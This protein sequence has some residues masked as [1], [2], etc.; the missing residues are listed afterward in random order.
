MDSRRSSPPGRL[1]FNLMHFGRLLRKAGM[2][3]G[4]AHLLDAIQTVEAV[5]L[6]NREDFYGALHAAFVKRRDEEPLFREAFDLFWRDPW[7][8]PNIVSLLLA[9]SSDQNLPSSHQTSRR[10]QEAWYARPDPPRPRPESD[11]GRIFEASMTWSDRATLRTKDFEQMSAEELTAAQRLLTRRPPWFGAPVSTRRWSPTEGRGERLHIRRLLQDHL[12]TLGQASPLRFQRRRLRPPP[13]V[14][15]CDISGSMERYSRMFLHFL[16]TLTRVRKRVSTFV[17]GTQL[18]NVTRLLQN[19]DVDRS[20]EHIG[21]RVSD[22]SGGTRIESSLRAFNREWAR[23]VLGQ[24]AVVLLMTDGLDR[25]SKANQAAVRRP[26]PPD[27][28]LTREVERIRKSCRRLT[29]LNPLLR[30][31]GFEPLAWGIRA[32]LPQVDDF[33]P[34]HNLASLEELAA[35][36]EQPPRTIGP[37]GRQAANAAPPTSGPRT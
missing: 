35:A 6:Q 4:P 29:W 27:S 13:L 10:L 3:V 7:G 14:A 30:F 17:F 28:N 22:W 37:R 18:W 1:I 33:R 34:V 8:G 16:H 21:H 19:R 24:G 2:P 36:L 12:R 25:D 20:L 23:R 26:S 15:I 31:D 32:I 11:P 9:Q 5:G